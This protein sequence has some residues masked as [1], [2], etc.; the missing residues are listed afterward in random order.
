MVGKHGGQTLSSLT[1]AVIAA[2][3]TAATAA[4]VEAVEQEE[5]ETKNHKHCIAYDDRS[6]H[7]FFQDLRISHRDGKISVLGLYGDIRR[8]GFC[9]RNLNARH[10]HAKM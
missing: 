9:S 10:I 7:H 6:T 3:V 4:K 2:A 8:R 5:E 1:S